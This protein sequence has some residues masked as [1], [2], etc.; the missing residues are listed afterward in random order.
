LPLPPGLSLLPSTSGVSPVE[1]SKVGVFPIAWANTTPFGQSAINLLQQ[2]QSGQFS[3]PQC[4]FIDNSTCPFTFTIMCNQTGHIIKVPPFTSG[5]F[6]LLSS[7]SPSYSLQLLFNNL[8]TLFGIQALTSITTTLYF[9]NTQQSPYINSFPIYG[10]VFYN[11]AFEATIPASG[12]GFTIIENIPNNAMILINAY[13]LSILISGAANTSFYLKFL[14]NE[15][16][17][18][19]ILVHDHFFIQTVT[20]AAGIAV[21]NISPRLFTF[22][23]TSYLLGSVFQ[24]NAQNFGGVFPTLLELDGNINFGFAVVE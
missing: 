13:T 2:W 7:Q 23:L 18:S 24:W 11:I 5:L 8:N 20:D 9:L 3:A 6:P 22:P 19:S 12:G 10:N 21:V 1:G 14:L 16:N 17:G 15:V 4:V